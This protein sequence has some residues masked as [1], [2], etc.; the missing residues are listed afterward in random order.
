MYKIFKKNN[1]LLKFLKPL[2]DNSS[3][4]LAKMITDNDIRILYDEED[5]M[6][7]EVNECPRLYIGML[8]V[9]KNLETNKKEEIGQLIDIQYNDDIGYLLVFK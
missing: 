1:T 5:K 6:Y 3:T 7:M 9:G 4:K 2:S 8:I